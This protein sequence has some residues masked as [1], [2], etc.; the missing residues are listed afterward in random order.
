MGRQIGMKRR[1]HEEPVHTCFAIADYPEAPDRCSV[2]L[3]GITFVTEIVSTEQ[4]W[5]VREPLGSEGVEIAGFGFHRFARRVRD[6]MEK[7]WR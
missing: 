4:R 2:R 7:G 1:S 6:A 5:Y 3:S